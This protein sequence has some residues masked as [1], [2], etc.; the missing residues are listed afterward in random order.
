MFIFCSS[1]NAQPTFI[2]KGR[3]EFVRTSSYDF[4]TNNG[5]KKYNAT[6][7]YSLVFDSARALFTPVKTNNSNNFFNGWNPFESSATAVFTSLT[8]N[9]SIAAK[10]FIDDDFL[11]TDTLVRLNWKI[12]KDTR[13]IAGFECRKATATIA[14][15]VILIAFFTDEIMPSFGPVGFTGLPGMMLGLAIPK[16]RMNWF[17]TKLELVPV[18]EAMLAPPVKGKKLTRTELINT[19]KKEYTHHKIPPSVYW[20]SMF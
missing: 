18:T 14:D 8:A 20:Q 5:S 2:T 15:S 3:I 12:T 4:F 13:T 7:N 1:A 19:L 17:A 10:T 11:V 6:D 9:K 16:M